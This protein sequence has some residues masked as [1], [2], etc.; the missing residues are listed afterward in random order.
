MT[1]KIRNNKI[2]IPLSTKPEFFCGFFLFFIIILAKFDTYFTKEISKQGRDDGTS[3]ETL[4]WSMLHTIRR[5]IQC[6]EEIA[7]DV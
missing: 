5:G 3:W 2:L 1:K 7:T 6:F 4:M